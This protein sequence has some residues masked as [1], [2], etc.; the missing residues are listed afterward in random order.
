MWQEGSNAIEKQHGG[1]EAG[2]HVCVYLLVHAKT[3]VHVWTQ[4]DSGRG[5][6]K[7]MGVGGGGGGFCLCSQ[8]SGCPCLLPCVESIS[9]CIMLGRQG[10]SECTP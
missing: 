7:R 3:G 6:N 4:M 10:P 5:G 2:D 9:D 1:E 8:W